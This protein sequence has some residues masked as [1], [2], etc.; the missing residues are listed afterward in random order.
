MEIRRKEIQKQ[1]KS[2]WDLECGEEHGLVDV[3]LGVVALLLQLARLEHVGEVGGAAEHE[4][5]AL[6]ARVTT[7]G[8]GTPGC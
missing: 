4:G 3:V 6:G 8:R 1:N 7:Q 2:W 5:A